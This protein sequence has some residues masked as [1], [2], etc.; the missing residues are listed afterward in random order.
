MIRGITSAHENGYGV[1]AVR[2][3]EHILMKCTQV[4]LVFREKYLI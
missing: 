1:W 2:G 4:V 3:M